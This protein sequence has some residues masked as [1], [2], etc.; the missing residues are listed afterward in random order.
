M[1]L[2][3]GIEEM[4]RACR[5]FASDRDTG[6]LVAD[7][8][9]QIELD[10]DLLSPRR[11]CVSRFAERF[12]AAGECLDRPR[13][14]PLGAAQDAGGKR[15]AIARVLTQRKCGVILPGTKHGKAAIGA[16]ELDKSLGEFVAL[17]IVEPIGKPQ[18]AVAAFLV[19]LLAERCGQSGAVGRIGFGTKAAD[20]L[21]RLVGAKGTAD[22]LTG[23]RRRQHDRA[24]VARR[25]V[26]C[27]LD[28]LAAFGPMRGRSPAIVDD[29]ENRAGAGQA[30]PVRIEHGP[31]QREDDQGRE[32]HAQGRQ[33]P[34]A[35]RR[36]LLG[37]LEI[38]QQPC[39][40]KDD[41]LRAWR[42]KP[43]Q[44]PNCGERGER[45]EHPRL[46]E[47]DR[48]DGDHSVRSASVSMPPAR[49][50]R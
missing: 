43:Q 41:E 38:L 29:D 26:D 48:A 8:E 24:A 45:R 50:D 35:T 27:R 46:K 28:R 44:P 11:Q 7:L 9:R 3:A 15:A 25:A 18:H 31:C 13:T 34:R 42:G 37:G 5:A 12:A 6:D 49:A 22:G 1:P 17:A 23:R 4:D 10:R 47:T 36:C 20:T 33:P 16:G 14:R 19:E 39:R 21:A 32:Q 2:R 30:L 40:R